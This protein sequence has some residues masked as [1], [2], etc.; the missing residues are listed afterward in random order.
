MRPSDFLHDE[1]AEASAHMFCIAATPERLE[2]S[3]QQTYWDGCPYIGDR[4]LY[5]FGM[6]RDVDIDRRRRAMFDGIAD[7][8][9]ANLR[10]AVSIPKSGA[11]PLS[12]QPEGAR[13]MCDAHFPQ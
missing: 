2:E 6:F 9:A 11:R 3:R 12:F 1:E 8:V 13:G 5:L 7:E 4:K 10:E